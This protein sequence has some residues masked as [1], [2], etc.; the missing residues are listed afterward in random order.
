MYFEQIKTPGLGC[1]SYALGCPKEGVM[2][3]V[4]PR[5]D[6]AVYLEI[7]NEH[8]MQITHI[9]ETHVH[10]DHISGAMELQHATG[11]KIYIHSSAPIAYQ[12]EK[13]EHGEVFDF[14]AFKLKVLHTPGHTPNSVSLVVSDHARSPSPAM[15]L[16]G[17]LLFVGDV[18]RPDLAGS[19]ILDEQIQNLFNSLNLLLDDLPE[20]L[21]VYPAHGQ[22]SLCGRGISSMPHTTLGYERVANNL[23][24]IK[25]FA[26]FKKSVMANLPMRPQSFSHIITTNLKGAALLTPYTPKNWEDFAIAA[27][28]FATM[29]E[30]GHIVLDLRDSLSFGAAHIPGSINISGNNPQAI[31]WIGTV[32]P[33]NSPLLLVIDLPAKFQHICTDLS[34][35]GYDDIKGYLHGGIQ[36]WTNKG[37]NLE[38]LLHISANALKQRLSEPN[39]PLLIDVRTMPEYLNGHLENSL[40]L[41]FEQLTANKS[42]P[43]DA[44][45]EKVVICQSGSRAAIA[46]SLL[47]ARG[48][49][50]I[51]LLA[52][53]LDSFNKL[54]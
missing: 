2:A 13:L 5:R 3:V 14:K 49:Q 37:Y 20:W 48:C 51:K 25:N 46:A 45:Q 47:Q 8:E 24:Q 22:G 35:I 42:C 12:A 9:F 41:P 31:N 44:M 17:D 10:A 4:D 54:T 33:P 32:I 6:I 30:Q 40:H 23:L 21:E 53:G 28:H 26:D 38:S 39:P 50:K 43:G 34:R 11:A 29:R 19:E 7:A 1:F 36:A 16:S 27:E 18:G 15:L 52:G